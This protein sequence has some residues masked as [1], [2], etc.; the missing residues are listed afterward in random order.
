MAVCA[1]HTPA[2]SGF[3]TMLRAEPLLPFTINY[4]DIVLLSGEDLYPHPFAIYGRNRVWG[5][6]MLNFTVGPVM[7]DEDILS[8]GAEQ[9][10]YFRTPEF[11][12]VM[13]ENE[14]LFL[15]LAG[16]PEGSRAV[17]LTGS[18]TA[19]MESAVANLLSSGDKALVVVG[20]S[21]GRRFSELC[22]IHGVPHDDIVIPTGKTLT[23]EALLKYDQRGYSALLV[24]I[25][26]TSTGV[27][28]DA[29]MLASFCKKNDCLFIMDAISSFLADPLNMEELGVDVFISGSQKALA[30]PPGVSLIALSK[31]AQYRLGAIDSGCLYLDL[32][33]ALKDGERGQTPFT[34]AVGILRQINLRLKQLERSGGAKAENERIA[35][36]AADFRNRIANLPFEQVS[37]A[38]SN[39]VTVLHPLNVS[40]YD[41]FT[42]LKDEYGIW[43]CPNG[44]EMAEKVFRVGHIG[45]LTSADNETLVKAF[46]DLIARNLL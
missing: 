21:F 13:F 22:D 40:A 30:C 38:P 8:V 25:H 15:E 28:Y 19:A 36:V 12:S 35:S 18:G 42:V 41:V 27:L 2:H 7:S 9:V 3:T 46:E 45:S 6:V 11:S 33:R 16:A 44:G 1:W 17:F 23:T 4:Q 32:K 34:P 29:E 37:P 26:E 14:K 43:V 24:N 31:R 20:G 5:V 10:P 39:A